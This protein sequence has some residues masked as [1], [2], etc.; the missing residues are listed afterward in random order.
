[1]VLESAP[2]MPIMYFVNVRT[3]RMITCMHLLPRALRM[4]PSSQVLPRTFRMASRMSPLTLYC[5][6]HAATVFSNT[7]VACFLP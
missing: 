7:S 6:S 3:P 4:I 1:M 2:R 5:A